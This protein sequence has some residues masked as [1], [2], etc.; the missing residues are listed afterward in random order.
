MFIITLLFITLLLTF[1][2][3]RNLGDMMAIFSFNGTSGV[4]GCMNSR[5]I[6]TCDFQPLCSMQIPY[7]V[8]RFEPCCQAISMPGTNFYADKWSISGLFN[9]T[10]VFETPTDCLT[11]FSS[12]K[13]ARNVVLNENC[14]TR[15][16]MDWTC[17]SL[18]I[19]S[20]A[21]DALR[22]LKSL[23]ALPDQG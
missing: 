3:A 8:L 10:V 11:T 7:S 20:I 19:C 18:K 16:T 9:G 2:T 6:T 4:F 22:G 21:F 5:F 1:V 15:L 12:A 23:W 13:A 17:N 14:N